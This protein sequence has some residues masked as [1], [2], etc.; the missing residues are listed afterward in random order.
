MLHKFLEYITPKVPDKKATLAFVG[1]LLFDLIVVLY[2][3]YTQGV[4]A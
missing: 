4:A 3:I 1:I 2:V